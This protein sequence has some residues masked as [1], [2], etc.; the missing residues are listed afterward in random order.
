MLGGQE[1]LNGV[2]ASYGGNQL[3]LVKFVVC[4]IGVTGFGVISELY[5]QLGRRN[6]WH[7]GLRRLG[8]VLMELTCKTKWYIWRQVWSTS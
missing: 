6:G 8:A 2:S 1:C 3:A 4:R 5:E 7:F